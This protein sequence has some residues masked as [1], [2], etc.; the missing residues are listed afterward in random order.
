M[1]VCSMYNINMMII[2]PLMKIQCVYLYM[3]VFGAMTVFCE[4]SNACMVVCMSIER[5]GI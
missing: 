3:Y 4:K 5:G 1:Y 2:F